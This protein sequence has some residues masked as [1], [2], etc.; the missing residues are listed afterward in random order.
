[1]YGFGF[2]S[3]RQGIMYCVSFYFIFLGR[4]IHDVLPHPICLKI[5]GGGGGGGGRRI[6]E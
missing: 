2:L 3:Y 1:M 6:V 4:N 5:W